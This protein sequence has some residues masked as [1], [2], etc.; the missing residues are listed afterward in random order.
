MELGFLPRA[1]VPGNI[2][3]VQ[4][5]AEFGAAANVVAVVVSVEQV[6]KDTPR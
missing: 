1:E 2:D 4:L 5:I 3:V 6:I